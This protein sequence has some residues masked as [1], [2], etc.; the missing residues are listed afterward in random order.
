MIYTNAFR[1]AIKSEADEF[2]V[3]LVQN[4]PKFDD[5]GAIIGTDSENVGSFVMSLDYAKN[6]SEK[7]N[8]LLSENDVGSE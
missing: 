7:I 4:S 8:E 1:L 3:S 6:L 5:Q 2:I